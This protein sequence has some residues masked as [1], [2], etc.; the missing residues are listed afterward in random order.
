LNHVEFKDYLL[1][2]LDAERRTSIEERMLVDP[3]V[4]EE[5]SAVEEELIDEYVRG[6]L[7]KL[8]Q[9]RFETHFLTTTERRKNLRFGR[10][11]KRYMDSHPDPVP[12][13]VAVVHTQH[14]KKGFPFY[15]GSFSKWPAIAF[16]AVFAAS[17]G[18]FFLGWRVVRKP[19]VIT[20]PQSP[21]RLVVVSLAPGSTRSTGGTT[22]VTVPPKGVDL[23]LELETNTTFSNYRSQVF[24]ES[25]SVQTNELKVEAKGDHNVVPLTITGEKLRPGDYKVKLCGVS[26]SGEKAFIDDYSFRVTT[27]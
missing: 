1:G 3:A 25:E 6:G 26:D 12:D 23:K 5:L 8:E 7:T 11:F 13:G 9:Q 14:A 21:S 17:V 20:A 27:E 16:L 2:A 24:R 22:H 4:C 18:I 19:A 15:V 10:L